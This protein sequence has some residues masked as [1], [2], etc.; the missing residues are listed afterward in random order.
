[1]D[2]LVV[3]P[4]TDTGSSAQIPA[5]PAQANMTPSAGYLAP[6]ATNNG[7]NKIH[8]SQDIWDRIDKAVHDE[9]M[10]TRVAQQFLPLRPVLPRTT[11]VPFDSIALPAATNPTFTVDE[12]LTTRLNEYFVE[13][14]LTPQQV[15][16]ES[17]DPMEL[18]HSTAVTL[19]THAAN[20][21]AQAEKVIS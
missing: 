21:L 17:G 11:S 13:F 12:G 2:T 8:W 10:R 18:G 14:S 20:I 16:H 5:T 3:A 1:M 4:P 15:D 19:A 7:R 6:T 9:M